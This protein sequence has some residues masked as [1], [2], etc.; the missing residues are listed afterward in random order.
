MR[1]F[2]FFLF[3]F[4]TLSAMRYP[5]YAAGTVKLKMIVANPSATEIKTVPVK[6]Y[7]PK[8]INPEDISDKGKF[9]IG[10]DFD[11]SLY[12]AYQ[13]VTLNPNESVTLELSMQ[14]IWV[15]PQEEINSLKGHAQKIVSSL[16]NTELY[17]QAKILGDSV[18]SR[19]D[20]ITE[21][22]ASAHADKE[23]DISNYE[24]NSAVLKE[25]KKD[26][27]VLEDLAMESGGVTGIGSD[28]LVGISASSTEPVKAQYTDLDIKELGT[29]KFKIEIS[30][31]SDKE[32]D[33]PLKYYLPVEVK[34]EYMVD[35]GGLDVGYDYQRGVQYVYKGSVKLAPNEKKE[36]TIEIKDVWTIPQQQINVLKA[37]TE[38]L[39]GILEESKYKG[40]AKYLAAKIVSSLDNITAAQNNANVSVERH[41]GNYRENLKKFDE[42]R[43]DI[44]KLERLVIQAGGSVGDT[45]IGAEESQG[46]TQKSQSKGASGS[47]I[48]R[49][50]KGMELIS[51]S[52]FRGKAPDTITSWKII[53]VIIGF[54]AVVSFL[55]FILWWTQI[56]IGAGKK[57]E[58]IKQEEKK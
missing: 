7:L 51:K 13:E 19:L 21:I 18:A 25:V 35:K 6:T 15:I 58:E 48:L 11:K 37:H 42:V 32:A 8:G 36:F 28:G 10:Y 34:P 17:N 31:P 38:K 14:D 40:P 47:V 41:I 45:V 5:L 54:L 52:I 39:I 9:E 12:Y 46:I 27:G 26:V 49:G 24:A 4:L 44:S 57:H 22:Q 16:K 20:K 50:A 55:F 33:V 2:I 23:Q 30:N 1:K 29:V 43:K 53:W 56:K 3:L